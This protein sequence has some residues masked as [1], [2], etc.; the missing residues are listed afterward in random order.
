MPTGLQIRKDSIKTMIIPYLGGLAMTL[1]PHDPKTC[2]VALSGPLGPIK[3]TLY[4]SRQS[5]QNRR[6]YACPYKTKSRSNKYI[7]KTIIS[8]GRTTLTASDNKDPERH[9]VEGP[10]ATLI[11]HCNHP[12]PIQSIPR[13]WSHLD[14]VLIVVRVSYG[15]T[16]IM[17]SVDSI[18]RA[19]QPAPILQMWNSTDS[20]NKDD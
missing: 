8:D 4:A 9:P 19:C 10:A 11:P 12:S 17:S 7:G 6:K 15:T 2:F 16:P 3:L 14:T 1:H 13:V 5:A 20:Q 18:R